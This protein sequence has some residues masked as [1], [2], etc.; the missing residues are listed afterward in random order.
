MSR[1]SGENS[2]IP[3]SLRSVLLWSHGNEHRWPRY[4]YTIV[5]ALGLIWGLAIAYLLLTPPSYSSKWTLIL[6]GKGASSNLN[7]VNIGQASTGSPSPYSNSATNPRSNYKELITSSTVIRMAAKRLGMAPSQFGAPRVKLVDQTSLIYL[8]IK[9]N[10]PEQARSKATALHEAFM[11]LLDRLRSDELEQQEMGGNGILITFQRKL[12]EASTKLLKYQS[13]SNIVS[14][15]QFDQLVL[16]LEQFRREMIETRAELEDVQGR[17][18]QLVSHL[19]VNPQQASDALILQNDK[20][21]SAALKEYTDARQRLNTNA[22]KWDRNHPEVRKEQARVSAAKEAMNR[23]I[24]TLLKARGDKLIDLLTLAGDMTRNALLQELIAIDA[25]RNGLQKRLDKLS[26][27]ITEMEHELNLLT[28]PAAMLDDL[29]RNHQVAEAVFISALA[30][31]DIAKSD[32]YVSFPLVQLL[33]EPLLPT[34]P[35]SPNSML[36]IA[37]AFVASIFTLTGLILMWIR[38]PF[39]RKILKNA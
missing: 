7:L 5:I 6:P 3:H 29:K 11:E 13:D 30:S 26:V 8:S 4:V 18:N 12:Q 22:S 25:E 1:S 38:K 20:L 39:L 36:T 28:R 10:S 2:L 31:T 33:D 9:G 24:N 37:G 21:F 14:M 19:G 27:L 23:R 16:T 32:I 17:S 35:S 34:E 15:K